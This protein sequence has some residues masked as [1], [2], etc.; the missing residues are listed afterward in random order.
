MK[1]YVRTLEDLDEK[2]IGLDFEIQDLL[3]EVDT[4]ATFEG[5]PPNP[6]LE[7]IS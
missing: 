7:E 2:R 3:N 4:E 5:I 6:T 1:H